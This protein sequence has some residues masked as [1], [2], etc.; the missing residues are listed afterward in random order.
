MR[1]PPSTAVVFS[2]LLLGSTGQAGQNLVVNPRFEEDIDGWVAGGGQVEHW[3]QDVHGG[4]GAIRAFARAEAY[5]GPR[6]DIT[7]VLTE[8]G[9]GTYYM[10]SWIKLSSGT[11]QHAETIVRV[12]AGSGWTYYDSHGDWKGA[13]SSTWTEVYGTKNIEWSGNIVGAQL[14]IQVQNAAVDMYVD[15][16][17]LGFGGPPDSDP[18]S[19]NGHP[20]S[21]QEMWTPVVSNNRSAFQ[22]DLAEAGPYAIQ[23][24]TAAGRLVWRHEDTWSGTGSRVVHW[25]E[26][27]T[28]PKGFYVGR[29]TC[30]RNDKGTSV[31]LVR[32]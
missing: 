10:S 28:A 26:W 27:N 18:V 13:N 4:K 12:D 23:V 14:Y 7:K 17:E 15:D 24:F 21:W 20:A 2:A 30:P 8:N 16:C 22:L 25:E 11:S 3:T 1:V 31:I 5:H 32:R 6:Q 19:V 9:P 29:L